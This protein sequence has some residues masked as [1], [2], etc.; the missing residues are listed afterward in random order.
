MSSEY[1]K[2]SLKI[3]EENVFAMKNISTGSLFISQGQP[4]IHVVISMGMMRALRRPF[5]VFAKKYQC[6][7]GF[8]GDD[9]LLSVV[10]S[11]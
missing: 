6:S 8:F 9:S 5:Y 10:S 7:G 3:N 11:V 2:V 1:V 4:L